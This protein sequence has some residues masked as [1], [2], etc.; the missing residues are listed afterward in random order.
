M[1]WT[2]PLGEDLADNGEKLTPMK[3]GKLRGTKRC[4]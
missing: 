4:F 2:F 1:I 3:F